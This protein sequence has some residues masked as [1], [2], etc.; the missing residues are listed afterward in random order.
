M[1][2]TSFP[3]IGRIAITTCLLKKINICWAGRVFH[4][5]LGYRYLTTVSYMFKCSCLY[6]SFRSVNVWHTQRARAGIAQLVQRL[7]TGWT[8]RGL[9]PGGG[10]DFPYPS[11]PSLGPAQSPIQ[12]ILGLS[13]GGKAAGAWCWPPTPSC[14]EAEGRVELYTGCF[15]IWGHYCCR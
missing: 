6:V 15:T 5:G 9:T 11:R 3:L 7:A 10:R 13:G 1:F 14:D 4:I 8:V 2:Y 12:W